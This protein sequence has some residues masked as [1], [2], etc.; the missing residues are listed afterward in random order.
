MKKSR[1]KRS[2]KKVM[3]TTMT[4]L[5]IMFIVVL[6][7]SNVHEPSESRLEVIL[8]KTPEC[9]CCS[10]YAEYLSV[11]KYK[12]ET[13]DLTYQ[14]LTRLKQELKIPR[15]LWSCHTLI[16]DNYTIEG[17]VPIA[18]IEKLLMESPNID[19]IAVPGMPPGAPGMPGYS[20]KIVVYYYNS[21]EYGVF[22]VETAT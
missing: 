12:V 14:G 21:G 1:R 8:Y 6:Q 22:Y 15:E 4:V 20:S 10:S 13:V 3:A 17:H 16:I 11:N 5:I 7:L 9:G 19:G 2:R 18:A